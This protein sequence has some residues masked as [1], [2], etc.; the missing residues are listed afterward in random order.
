[1]I[2]VHHL[3]FSRST[4]AIWLLE[5]LGQPYEIVAH[6]RNPETLRAPASLEAV[7]P[8]GKAPV[9]EVT[10]DGA[11]VKLAE[12]GAMIEY[13]VA[14]YGADRLAPAQGSAEWA[15]YIEWLHYAEGSA[16]LPL[17]VHLLGGLTG[18]LSAGLSGF[19]APD[20]DRT[21]RYIGAAVAANGH[22]LAS[23]FSGADVQMAYVIEMARMGKLTGG[24]PELE[25]YMTRLEARPA[26]K[27]AIERGGPMRLPL[28]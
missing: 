16:M 24:H 19:I 12:S 10:I 2:R 27:R 6:T 14:T 4:R 22:L 25:A 7:H 11:V 1:M 18:G 26:F 15:R 8:L 23:G 9:V 28:G 13:L 20:I 21:L 5:E 3:N 17:L